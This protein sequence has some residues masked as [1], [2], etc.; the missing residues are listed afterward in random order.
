MASIVYLGLG[1]NLGDRRKNLQ[2]AASALPPAVRV[3]R[4]SPVY[5]TPPWGYSDQPPFYNQA[6]EVET[7]LP[8]LDLLA[9]LKD[10]ESKLGRKATFHYGP[11]QID[12]D[13]LFYGDQVFQHEMLTIPHL[14]LHERAFILVPLADLAPDLRHPQLGATV[15]EMLA[16]VDPRGIRRVDP[17]SRAERSVLPA[18]GKRTYIMGILNVTPDSFSGDG[19][20]NQADASAAALAQARRFIAAGADIL[21]IGGESTRPGSSAVDAQEE[22]NR[23]LPVVQA[24]ASE[25]VETI[26]SVDTYKAEVAEAA[27]QAGADWINDVWALRADPLLAGVAARS[28]APVVLMHNRIK[29]NSAELQE[30]LGWRYT[31]IHYEN[32]VEDV[33]RELMESVLLARQA[34]VA[35][36]KIIIDPG[37][38]FGKTVEQSLELLDRLDEIRALGFPLLLGPSRKSFIGYTL[39]LPVDERVEGTAAA[40]AIGID[41][42]ADIVRVHDVE[43]MVRVARMTDAIVRRPG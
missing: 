29:P 21:D 43:A 24:L 34:G 16:G 33:R 25:G 37:L 32:L 27:L 36:E 12:L 26:L 39:N 7:D 1:T 22:L 42:G 35:D 10:L 40:V 17:L 13:I 20:L 14:R 3:L 6:L 38:G 15:R 28:G 9:Y 30:R 4:A 31:G 41:R 18:W 23:I 11:R 5:E 8:P 19:L 2:M